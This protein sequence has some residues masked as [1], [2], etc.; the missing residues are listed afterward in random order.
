MLGLLA[1]YVASCRPGPSPAVTPSPGQRPSST[2]RQFDPSLPFFQDVPY[3]AEV[4]SI[5]DADL[6]PLSCSPEY[7]SWSGTDHE[8]VDPAT[9]ETHPIR[10]AKIQSYLDSAI[11]LL[12]DKSI[13]SISVC[14]TIDGPDLVIFGAGPCGGGCAGIP[15]IAFGQPDAAL[16]LIADIL[17]DGDGPY[18]SCSALQLT[19][20]RQLYLS[21]SGE[22]TAIIRRV[23]L[24]EGDVSI[25]LKCEQT[26]DNTGC[27]P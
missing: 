23:D 27:A 4:L 20:E 14:E 10:E 11:R 5:E 2:I 17:P 12:P 3:P 26:A 1:L 21:C 25:I 7:F 24:S 19:A 6:Q 16:S 13:V 18:Y 15:H 22:G 8:S 9:G